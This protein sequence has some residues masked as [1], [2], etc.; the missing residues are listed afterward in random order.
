MFNETDISMNGWKLTS[1]V[2]FEDSRIIHEQQN[3]FNNYNRV[4]YQIILLL[5]L[6]LILQEEKYDK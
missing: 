6:N 3:V 5:L 2:I 1:I 4:K